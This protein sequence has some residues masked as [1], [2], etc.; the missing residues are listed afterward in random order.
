MKTI[1]IVFSDLHL[2]LWSRFNENHSRTKNAFEFID[3][4]RK[5]CVIENCP[6]IFGGDFF[7]KP[8]NIDN[9]LF[10]YLVH[11]INTPKSNQD[12]N[13]KIYGISGNHDMNKTN[14]IDN[15][16]PS[17]WSSICNAWPHYFCNIDLRSVEISSGIW[18]HGVPYLDH[19]IGLND[20][21]QS[22]KFKKDTKNILL[23]HTDY[24]GAKDTDGVVVDSVEN[25]NTNLLARFD[26]T[27]IGH[28]HK[29]QRMGRRIYMIGA[30]FQ[31]RR[32]DRDCELGYWKLY[33]NMSLEFV[34]VKSFPRF[35]D[36]DSEDKKKDDGNYYTVVVSAKDIPEI[37]HKSV[38]VGLSKKKIVSR[39]LKAIHE[40]SP[41]KKKVLLEVLNEVDQ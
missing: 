17:L 25:L 18:L 21:I 29:P 2:N 10:S 32:T 41:D 6:A 8:E 33:D 7:H 9:E 28:I 27:L 24:P 19:N 40:D 36:V 20:Y 3:I 26:I 37:K 35:I 16:S 11:Y 31:Q 13:V 34:P 22:I 1:A 30:P 39:Y 14:R 12:T 15:P 38:S 23:L 5:Q 4:V